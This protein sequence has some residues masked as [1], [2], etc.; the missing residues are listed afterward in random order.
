MQQ[1]VTFYIDLTVGNESDLV[2]VIKEI[3]SGY[4]FDTPVS[5]EETNRRIKRW[6]DDIQLVLRQVRNDSEST[7]YEFDYEVL[8]PSLFEEIS[9]RCPEIEFSAHAEYYNDYY[10]TMNECNVQYTDGK[11]EILEPE[12]DGN[13]STD[14]I[15]G[16]IRKILIPLS[17][18]QIKNLC[19]N[20]D[21]DES[22]EDI[23]MAIF[24]EAKFWGDSYDELMG[25]VTNS[26]LNEVMDVAGII[27]YDQNWNVI[28]Y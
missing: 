6:V 25:Y 15:V 21:I 16:I 20:L 28:H 8:F 7:M 3:V 10:G 22:S 27:E 24:E 12:E 18:E 2:D 23:A 14:E 13:N 11:L 26:F 17:D 4:H 5:E 9:T 1:M 19:R